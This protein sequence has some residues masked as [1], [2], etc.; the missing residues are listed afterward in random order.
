[1]WWATLRA[2]VRITE[3]R[4]A[5]WP[6]FGGQIARCFEESAAVHGKL[7]DGIAAAD[8]MKRGK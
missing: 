4:I 1:L 7:E 5:G 3:G 8:S 2:S 6:I